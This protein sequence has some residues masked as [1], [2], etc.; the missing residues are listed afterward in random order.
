VT[1]AAVIAGGEVACAAGD[2]GLVPETGLL[3]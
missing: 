2:A 1:L 3:P